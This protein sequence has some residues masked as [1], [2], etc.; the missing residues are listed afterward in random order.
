MGVNHNDPAMGADHISFHNGLMFTA[1][2][3]GSMM[4]VILTAFTMTPCSGLDHNSLNNGPMMVVDTMT[5]CSGLDHNGPNNGPMVGVDTM[6]PCSGLD[7]N[8][9]NNG[10]MMGVDTMTPCSVLDHNSP[11]NGPMMGVD[12][13]SKHQLRGMEH[14]SSKSLR[15]CSVAIKRRM[16]APHRNNKL[17][18]CIY[19]RSG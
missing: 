11:N 7:H 18:N 13:N 6:T 4:G 8:S 10:P 14:S 5:P 2:N 19:L 3:N 12:T 15:T 16:S 17:S 1:T 9:L